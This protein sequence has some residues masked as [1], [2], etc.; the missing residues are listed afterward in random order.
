ME[1]VYKRSN[2]YTLFSILRLWL[3]N[4]L[5]ISYLMKRACSIS[6]QS[7]HRLAVAQAEIYNFK[8]SK[9]EKLP[10]LYRDTKQEG[11]ENAICHFLAILHSCSQNRQTVPSNHAV[12]TLL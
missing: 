4:Y 1:I 5:V 10:C 2:A 6:Q 8:S 11:I 3:F 7:E 12:W 9:L